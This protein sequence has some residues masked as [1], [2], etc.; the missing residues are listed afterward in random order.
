M[1]LIVNEPAVKRKPSWQLNLG[2]S[3]SKLLFPDFKF[4]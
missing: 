2:N 3:D 1:A 4:G